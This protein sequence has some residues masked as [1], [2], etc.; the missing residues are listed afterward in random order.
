MSTA[1][2]TLYLQS[3]KSTAVQLFKNHLTE[4]YYDTFFNISVYFMEM[5]RNLFHSLSV[6]PLLVYPVVMVTRRLWDPFILALYCGRARALSQ[7]KLP[8]G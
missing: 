4:L 1:P 7:L 3:D 2:R 6:S 8:Q 5:W